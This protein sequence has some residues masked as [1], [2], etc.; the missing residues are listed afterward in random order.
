MRFQNLQL[1]RYGKFTDTEVALPKAE[2]DF[3]LIIGP[4]E[5]GKSTVRGAIADLL[6]GFPARAAAMAF[7]HPQPD[8]RL[9]A[10]VNDGNDLLDFVRVK[11]AKNTL[12]SSTDAPLA[13]D[14][15]VAFLGAAD[16]GFFEKMFGL[17]HAQLVEGG[18]S[19]LDASKDVSQ[20]LF[21][22]AAGI[23]G[24]GKVKEGLLSE[25]EKLW[26]PRHSA[27][28][29]YYAASDQCDVAVKDLKA[30]TVRTKAWDEARRALE[31]VEGRIATAKETKTA[32]QT[33][34]IKLERVRRLAPTVQELRAK[35]GQLE[36]QGDVLELPANASTIL[37]TGVSELSVAETVV[38]QCNLAVEQLTQ[39]REDAI[40]DAEVL[41]VKDDIEALAAFGESVR[42]HYTD[43]PVRQAEFTQQ[44]SLARAAAAELGWPEDETALH[45]RLPGPLIVREI[46]RLVTE[47]ARLLETKVGAAKA[48]NA[49]QEELD[50]ATEELGNTAAREVSA[51]LRS[52]ISEAQSHRNTAS[53]QSKL[54]AAV[55]AADRNL[56]TA[57][58]SLGEWRRDIGVLQQMSV[59]ST[60]RLSEL[61][62]KRQLLESER[63]AAVDRADEAQRA[64]DDAMLA[65]KQYAEA[66]HIVTGTEVREARGSRDAKW[67]AIKT[68]NSPLETAAAG[69]DTAIALAD[70]LVD[71]QLGSA[72]EAAELQSLKQREER[73]QLDLGAR[74]QVKEKK[75]ADML[76]FDHE[77]QAL[78]SALGLPGLPLA[79]AQAW[80]VKRELALAAADARGAKD[81]ELQQEVGDAQ[82][83]RGELTVQLAQ[84]GFTVQEDSGLSSLLAQAEAQV[85]EADGANARRAQ[86]QKQL[87]AAKGT[88]NRLKTASDSAN[89]AYQEWETKWSAVIQSAVLSDF[90]KTVADAEQALVKLEAV[91]QNLDKANATK[92]DRIDEMN[93]DLMEFNG[94]ASS[95]VEQLGFAELQD[96]KVRDVVRALSQRLRDAEAGH[97]R[98]SAAEEALRSEV[99]K[100]DDAN[101]DVERVSAKVAPLLAAAGVETLADAVP[102]FEKSDLKRRLSLEVEQASAT[103]EQGSD[104]LGLDVVIAE[105]ESSDLVQV[106]T[107]LSTL[108][109]NLEQVHADLTRLAEERLRTEQVLHAI[110][111]GND[112]ASAESR[113]QEALASMADASDR[114]IKVTTAAKLLT[115]AIDRYREQNQGPMLARAGTI[116]STL[117]LGQYS[118]LFVDYEKTN[119]SLSAL[120]KNGQVVEVSGLSEGTRDQLYLALRLAALELHLAKSKALPF[121]ADDLF[122]NFD[123][124]RSTAGLEALRELSTHT[125]V[126][127]LSH[128]D[129]LLPRVQQVFGANVNVVQLER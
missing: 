10:Q 32:L 97:A 72:T 19:I 128:H 57:L 51:L 24:L 26:A 77:W 33:R 129:H 42:N 69:L 85:S 75:D 105:V 126:L 117:T 123:D 41:A 53:N 73:S 38:R 108:D 16:R 121:V 39:Q 124:E 66:R 5:A 63:D 12:R 112:A 9:A 79:D 6:F 4:N 29:V 107:D 102:L 14:A 65:V 11:A 59:P 89:T 106:A 47:H 46:Q 103:L 125:Q 115:W 15:L 84:A 83:A 78:A 95:L 82:A 28:R 8:L 61:L 35:V 54:S 44:M 60:E 76:A 27:A 58:S 48:V 99:K 116:F 52:A 86:L 93:R 37:G 40:Y 20:V 68:G 36:A 18:Q 21:Q 45:D 109:D 23:A 120:R 56:E 62:K 49:K 127:F 101:K 1:V 113:R 3:H 100:L 88:L 118:K 34:R 43:L 111:G 96:T 7:L 92:R 17:G 110:G 64:L 80:M 119:L 104:G 91:R 98:R 50:E 94:M 22:S 13:D 67:H 122:I 55:K 74:Q 30:A 87:N 31:E 114:F 71:S 25:A 90:V 81:G 70:E 2:H